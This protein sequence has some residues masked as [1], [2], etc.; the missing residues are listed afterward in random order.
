M[1]KL[2]HRWGKAVFPQGILNKYL[3]LQGFSSLFI[4][5]ALSYY[6][7]TQLGNACK[8]STLPAVLLLCLHQVLTFCWEVVNRIKKSSSISLFAYKNDI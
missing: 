5:H 2:H 3:R 7:L 4:K 1:N 6:A 8:K